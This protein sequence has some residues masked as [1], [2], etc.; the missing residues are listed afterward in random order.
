M[1]PDTSKLRMISRRNALSF[2][3]S[4]VG[5]FAMMSAGAQ[6]ASTKDRRLSGGVRHMV[7]VTFFKRLPRCHHSIDLRSTR[8]DQSDAS[9]H[10]RFPCRP[11]CDAESAKAHFTHG[12]T[13]DFADQAARDGYW[14]HPGH[15]A[16]GERL[17]TLLK[18]SRE[19]LQTVQMPL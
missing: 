4:G 19:D 7:F 10:H 16:A 6:E 11:Q 15:L 17:M 18:R 1:T 13:I 3:I 9:G 12:F 14:V 5:F 8:P 2:A